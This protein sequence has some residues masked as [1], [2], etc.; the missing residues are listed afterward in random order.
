MKKIISMTKA[1]GMTA[2][3][4]AVTLKSVYFLHIVKENF[5]I[6][7]TLLTIGMM[8]MAL[9]YFVS[10]FESNIGKIKMAFNLFFSIFLVGSIFIFIF[11]PGGKIMLFMI[12]AI[13]PIL[14]IL[15]LTN[16]NKQ[17]TSIFKYE[18]LIWVVSILFVMICLV[19]TWN[20][21]LNSIISL[22][23]NS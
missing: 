18:D 19:I 1:V 8:L 2:F 14:M 13:L 11:L 23:L 9:S 7:N 3:I 5:S 10:N 15:T 6:S 12:L 20:L 22:N 4:T 21:H 16:L 17:Q